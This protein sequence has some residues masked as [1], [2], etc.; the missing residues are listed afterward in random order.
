MTRSSRALFEKKNIWG[1]VLRRLQLG[2]WHGLKQKVVA[3]SSCKAEYVA[4]T[5]V[6]TRAVWLTQLLGDFKGRDTSTVELKVNNKLVLALLKNPIFHERRKHN[7]VRYHFIREC[8]DDGRISANFV[9][10]KDQLANNQ[11]KALGRVKFL[12]L[13][14]RIGMVCYNSKSTQGSRRRLLEIILCLGS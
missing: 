13:H 11:T 1:H 7:D 2:E 6:A 12:E 4:A 10:T 5:T 14:A 3:L 9:G 8:L